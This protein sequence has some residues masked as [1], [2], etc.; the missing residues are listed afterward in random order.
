MVHALADIGWWYKDLLAAKELSRSLQS[1]PWTTPP[2]FLVAGAVLIRV[3]WRMLAGKVE[4]QAL[5]SAIISTA[6]EPPPPAFLA[7]GAVLLHVHWRTPAGKVEMQALQ[8]AIISTAFEPG[9]HEQVLR[10]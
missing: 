4:M 3:R 5:Q 2:V 8:S 10:P 6:F 9:G 1:R 7:A